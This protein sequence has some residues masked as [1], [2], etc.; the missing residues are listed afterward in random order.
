MLNYREPERVVVTGLGCVSP[1][2][3]DVNS[4][5]ESL[6]AG[7]S[8]I[9][10]I[11]DYDASSLSTRFAGTV[12]NFDVSPYLAEKD[13]KRLDYFMQYGIAAAMQAV[14]DAELQTGQFNPDRFGVM[15][16]SGI[17]GI[18]SIEQQHKIMLDKG[19]RR[20]SPFFVPGTITNMASGNISIL[21]NARGP[22]LCIT[23]ACAA[24][25]HNIGFAARLIATGDADLMLAGGAEKGST[26]LGVAGFAAA[27]ALS[28]NNDDPTGASRP[29]DKDRD[30]FV[31]ADGD[32]VLMLESLSHALA[33]GANIYA[34]LVGFGVSADAHHITAPPESGEGA[35]RA[36]KLSLKSAGLTPECIDYVNA[37]GT[38]TPLGDLVEVRALK[39]VFGD[40]A[41]RLAIS[42]TKSMVGHMLGAAGAVEALFSVLSLRHQIAPPTINLRTPSEEC[43]LDFVPNDARRMTMRYALSN[44]FGFGG[45]N[46][47]LVFR[48]WEDA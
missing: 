21:A 34:E 3:N 25:T 18:E 27:R 35:A 30:G 33:R 39:S 8:G 13:A 24:G 7:K 15:V 20:V 22:N 37:H 47:S 40:R 16:G 5:W 11:T 23:T 29:W 12:K 19:P 14:N 1:L 28:K 36:V 31:L 17:G 42:S 4:T 26:M 45:T 10:P 38:S 32:G 44:S 46:G 41:K 2:G 48:Q 9:G 43:D 6:V